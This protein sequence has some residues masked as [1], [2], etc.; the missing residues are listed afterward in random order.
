MKKKFYKKWHRHFVILIEQ[1][2][3]KLT[4]YLPNKSGRKSRKLFANSWSI[5]HIINSILYY[6]SKY[7]VLK[8]SKT[9]QNYSLNLKVIYQITLKY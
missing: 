4:L 5:M 8:L 2:R 9:I 1:L 6:S 3:G 7:K